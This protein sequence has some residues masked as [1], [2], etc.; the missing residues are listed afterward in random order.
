MLNNRPSKYMKQNLI[1]LHMYVPHFA[2]SFPNQR[3]FG[4]FPALGFCDYCG[5]EYGHANICCDCFQVYN[6]CDSALKR[7][8]TLTHAASWTNMLEDIMLSETS[9]SLKDTL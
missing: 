1:E 2:H 7:N 5:Y 3:T 4:L 8:E 6:I 9:Q